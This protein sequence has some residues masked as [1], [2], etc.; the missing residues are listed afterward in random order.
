MIKNILLDLAGVILNLDIKRDTKSLVTAGLPDWAG[1]LANEPLKKVLLEHLNGLMSW[2]DFK[3]AILPYCKEGVTEEE[4]FAAMHD[5]LGDI[6]VSRLEWIISLRAKY[7]VYLLSNISELSWKICLERFD[8]AGHKPDECFDRMF[9]S[10][11]MQLAKPDERIYKAVEEV[12]GL[13]PTE[14][15]YLDDTRENI[16]AANLL[17][18]NSILVPMNKLETITLPE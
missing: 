9:L 3:I 17:G 14:T 6:P 15:I 13:I 1:C 2:E 5:V 8:A 11:E 10:Y 7:N 16:E 4:L 18:Y 12:T